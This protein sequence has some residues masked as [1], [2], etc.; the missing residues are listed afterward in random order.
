MSITVKEC[1]ELPGFAG[2]YVAGGASGLDTVVRNVSV[3]ETVVFEDLL[4]N[5]TSRGN[6]L[7]ISALVSVADSVE[8]QCAALRTLSHGG[9]AG[10]ILFY[11]G[12][13]MDELS[14]RLVETADE[15]GFPLIIMPCDSD[16]A[17]SDII[18]EIMDLVLGNQ[19]STSTNVSE[20]IYEISRRNLSSF[21]EVMQLLAEKFQC[22]LVI[23]DS[24]FEPV[25][26]SAAPQFE[27]ELDFDTIR[28]VIKNLQ[29]EDSSNNQKYLFQHKNGICKVFS[30]PFRSGSELLRLFAF[31]FAAALSYWDLSSITSIAGTSAG[32]WKYKNDKNPDADIVQAIV[33][34]NSTRAHTLM[35]KH[36]LRPAD[37]QSLLV[38]IDPKRGDGTAF[39]A[40]CD[41]VRQLFAESGIRVLAAHM[42][43]SLVLVPHNLPGDPDSVKELSKRLDALIGEGDSPSAYAFSALNLQGIAEMGETYR[44]FD[45][46]HQTLDVIFPSHRMLNKYHL[47]FAGFCIDIINKSENAP[48]PYFNMLAPLD[49]QSSDNLIDTL[50]IFLLD[51]N[52]N[53]NDTAGLMYVHVNTVQYR[54]RRIREI[55]KIDLSGQ[56]EIFALSLSL[57]L[58]R[59]L[60]N[61]R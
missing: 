59:L 51:A 8:Q 3:L 45:A 47:W 1:L 54:L 49:S 43:D 55:L 19:A 5:T 21:P 18:A 58:R 39:A 25:L 13:V 53:A 38:L 32:I 24:F 26:V 16:L 44:D 2:A 7:V 35:A 6:E 30:K 48:S 11:V 14:P 50:A 33:S 17:Y 20:T 36:G 15:L 52:L 46:R 31:D 9:E 28:S 56:A 61:P 41:E 22:F 29:K 12:I 40:K 27:Q 37:F 34:G 23:T 42:V 57:A 60:H 10:L 4:S